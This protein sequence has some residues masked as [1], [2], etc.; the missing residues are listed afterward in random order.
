MGLIQKEKMKYKISIIIPCYNVEKT[1]NRCINSII[2]Q[3]FD[4]EN[5][6]LI[7]YDDGSTDST[8][9]IIQNYAEIYGNIVFVN[10][11]KN[12]GPGKG[13]NEGIRLASAEYV[14]FID[15]D[16]E[17]D[18]NLCEFFYNN[19]C[20]SDFDLV[21]CPSVNMI[22]GSSEL[23]VP[24]ISHENL[25]I[26]KEDLL[27]FNDI[28]IFNKIYKRSILVGESILFPEHKYGE[29]LQFNIQYFM[30]CNKMLYVPNYIG[31]YRHVQKDSISR[32]WSLEDLCNLIQTF[33]D[34][35]HELIKSNLNVDFN[36]LFRNHIEYVLL[37]LCMLHL[38]DN[39]P[40]VIQLLKRLCS[41]EQEISF[42][43]KL[44]SKVVEIANAFLLKEQFGLSY[45]YLKFIEKLYN[46]DKIKM[47]YRK[48][49]NLR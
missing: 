41:F 36:R 43:G 5:I 19:M 21:C 11:N 24:K 45:N 6:E 12:Q 14:M 32:S 23:I 8:K 2:N 20:D 1:F 7:I 37:K 39:K 49:I 10:S 44:N 26:N 30:H 3:S 25:I 34:I 18:P 15:S 27:Y 4:F 16:D 48:I 33:S 31:H 17:Y 28:F 35:Y 38:L 46:L 13:R 47:F 29:D 42:N 22:N 40:R 9:E